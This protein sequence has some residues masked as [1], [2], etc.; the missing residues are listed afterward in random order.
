[1]Q[2]RLKQMIYG[3]MLIVILLGLIRG[4]WFRTVLALCLLVFGSYLIDMRQVKRYTE[5]I[6][7][8]YFIC[9]DFKTYDILVQ[10]LENSLFY[11]HLKAQT[12][13]F[14]DLI[15]ALI[16]RQNQSVKERGAEL[17]RWYTP[18]LWRAYSRFVLEHNLSLNYIEAIESRYQHTYLSRFF[19][20]NLILQKPESERLALLM[21][22]RGESDNNLQFAWIN[23]LIS[24]LEVDSGRRAYYQRIAT[25]IAPEHFPPDN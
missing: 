22:A 6:L 20:V 12:L 7:N 24:D 16:P 13:I 11:P 9:T 3:T 1:M 10:E 2:K 15:K 4:F 14:F 19:K 8:K 5:L 17:D 23:W 25:N 18:D 21:V